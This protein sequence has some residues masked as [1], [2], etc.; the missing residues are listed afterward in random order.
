MAKEL[1]FNQDAR[2]RLEAGINKLAEAVKATLGPK[3]CN[4]ILDKKFGSPQITNDGVTIAK[5]IELED[6]FENMGAQ[7][8][9]EV[10]SKTN[11]VA[12]DGTT[13]A[14]LLAQTIVR[15]GLK[16]AIAGHNPMALKRGID[17]G[18]GNSILIKFNQIGSLT[19]TLNAIKMAKDAG[20]TAVISHRSGETED[21]TIADLAVGTA[22]GQIK[23]GSL[24]RSDRVAKYNQLLRISENC[25]KYAD[26]F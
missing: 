21:A 19:E 3:G 9:K 14:T 18:I 10:A 4:V 26:M 25:N 13:T 5:E 23:T 22:A 1:L 2:N 8:L 12:G 6:A 17:N 20:F 7:L 24:C 11:D 16:H 15:E